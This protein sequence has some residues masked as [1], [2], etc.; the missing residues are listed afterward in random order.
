MKQIYI[1]D[2][3]V[4]ASVVDLRSSADC[5]LC[6][7][8]GENGSVDPFG[9]IKP[10]HTNGV[11]LSSQDMNTMTMDDVM[12]AHTFLK[13]RGGTQVESIIHEYLD[14][15]CIWITEAYEEYEGILTQSLHRTLSSAKKSAEKLEELYSND[16]MIDVS[17]TPKLLQD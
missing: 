16:D 14:S 17:V 10:Q 13:C 4:I 9:I 3:V 12:F 2:I 8:Y 5:L 6:V 7:A 1:Q 11:H 15:R